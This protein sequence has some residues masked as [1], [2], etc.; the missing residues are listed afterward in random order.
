MKEIIIFSCGDSNDIST[1]SN[2]PYL[3][4]KTLEGKGYKLNRVDISP[5]K[6]IN[7][8]FN[9][10]AYI[11]FKRILKIFTNSALVIF[12]KPPKVP[13][14]YPLMIPAFA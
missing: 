3:F 11:I 14:G 6:I 5:N 10:T 1:W 8:V 7:R 13:S 9:T 2:V 12:L 4:T